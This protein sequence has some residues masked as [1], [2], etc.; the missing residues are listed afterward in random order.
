MEIKVVVPDSYLGDIM[1]DITSRRG[2]VLGMDPDHKKTI[3]HA[4]C[5]LAELQRY[6][7]DL[8]SMTSGQGIFTMEF[9]GYEDVPSNLEAKIIKESPF[10]GAKDEDDE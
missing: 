7:P 9:E 8:R 3:I 1:G 4:V 2:R 5:P 6:A 10:G